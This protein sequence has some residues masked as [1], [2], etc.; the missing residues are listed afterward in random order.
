[1]A[2]FQNVFDQEYQGYLV[3]A[4]RKLSPTFKVAPNK[5]LQSQQVAWNKAPYDFSSNNILEFNFAW[6]VDFKQWAKITI[7][8]AG[9]TPSSTKAIEVVSALNSNPTFS[10]VLIAKVT[11]LDN[12]ETVHIS[13]KT[14]KNL[15]FYFSN[16]GAETVLGFNKNA[17]VAE[18][19]NYF[20]RHT[21]SNV[22]NFADSAGL[23]IELD[24]SNPID[25]QV[26]QN[27][28][29][30]PS[31]EQE[32]WQLLRGRGAGLF[33]FQKMIVDSNDRITEIIEYPAGSV[34][35]DFARKI[36]YVYTG[37]NTSPNQVVEIPYVL[38]NSDLITP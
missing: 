25:Q 1:M 24:T 2:F 11:N 37:A 32:D 26:I 29:F 35:G 6:D 10:S 28:G 22:N 16:S 21:T 17:G 33:T 8:V 12:E 15:K 30:D 23:L 9:S 14:A 27:A 38:Q 7:D 4:D 5:N 20:S 13:K 34:A 18:L 19:P 3:L 31:N 36:K